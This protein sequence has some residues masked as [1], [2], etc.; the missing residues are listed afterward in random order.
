MAL[1]AGLSILMTVFVFPY[2]HNRLPEHIFL[3]L[4]KSALLIILYG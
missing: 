3:R 2:L 4:C 1:S